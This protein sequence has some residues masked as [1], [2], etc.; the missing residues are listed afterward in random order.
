MGF[1]ITAVGIL[2]LMMT[3]QV[4]S[5]LNINQSQ[6]CILAALYDED[7]HLENINR[8]TS[9]TV[10]NL[11]EAGKKYRLAMIFNGGGF[12]TAMFLGIYKGFKNNGLAP[13]LVIGTCGGSVAASISHMIEN[14]DKQLDFL[15][16]RE[17]YQFLKSI[18]FNPNYSSLGSALLL[19]RRMYFH[20]GRKG[21]IPNIFERYLMNV[22]QYFDISSFNNGFDVNHQATIVV[23][24][25][26]LFD[27]DDVEKHRGERKLFQEVLFTDYATADK[28]RSLNFHAPLANISGS[29][30]MKEVD[31]ISN[32]SIS[33]AVR[34]SI[35]D[36]F[37]MEPKYLSE[38][39]TY[40]NTGAIDIYPIELA[41]GLAEEVVILKSSKYT[42]VELS[43]VLATYN[44]NHN[45]R[46]K[47][48]YNREI[49]YIVKT[50]DFPS[51]LDFFP[52]PNLWKWKMES[53]IPE[54][55]ELFR[56]KILE[57]YEYGY[58]RAVSAIEKRE[59][60]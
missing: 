52:K 53:Q 34:A 37:L 2:A 12:K 50:G 59:R 42:F 43:G 14:P 20:Y 31:V 21:I 25:K 29:S 24:A 33:D 9:S 30:V 4:V 3:R 22:P 32:V 55:Y 17:F 40:A 8:N 54:T 36:M 35:A 38:N 28:I 44:V 27:R 57:Q 45:D 19:A 11:Q 18:S 39:G 6:D 16:S 47:D 48:V 1:T 41:M 15:L 5:C 49:Q 51:E 60:E 46:Y 58:Q 7:A 56:E 10:S 26:L 23:A 13:D